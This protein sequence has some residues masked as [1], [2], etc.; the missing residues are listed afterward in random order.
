MQLHNLKR[1]RGLKR[2]KWLVEAVNAVIT[3][4][5]GTKGQKARAGHRI[6]P[7]IRDMIKIVP[8]SAGAVKTI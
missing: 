1:Q 6:R 5:K 8:V 3:S 2:K 4:G 7:E